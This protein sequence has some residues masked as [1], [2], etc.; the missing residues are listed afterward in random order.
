MKSYFYV[1]F[2]FFSFQAQAQNFYKVSGTA[3]DKNQKL[4]L[5]G[6]YVFINRSSDNKEWAVSTDAQGN[7]NFDGLASGQYT[8]K[9]TYIGFKAKQQALEISQKDIFLGEILLDEDPLLLKQ[10]DIIGKLPPAEQK[11]DTTQ[12]NAKAF[13][14]NPD[15]N[16]EDLLQ[17]MPGV[18]LQNGKIQAQ[19]E[20]VKQVLVD[21]K[22]FFG[23]DPNA[24]LKNLP[25]EIIDKIQ[26]FDQNSEQSQFTGFNDGNTT[27]TINIVTKPE[28][29][30]GQFGQFYAGYGYEDKYQGGGNLNVFDKNRRVSILGQSNNINQQNFSTEDLLGVAGSSGR[31]GG[32]RGGGDA[33]MGGGFGGGMG[34]GLLGGGVG[35]DVGDFLVGQQNGISTTHAFGLN[36]SDNW[37][38]KVELTASYFFNRSNNDARQL[39]NR[40]YFQDSDTT[41]QYAEN[42]LEG[43]EN[44]NHRFNLRLQYQIDTKNSIIIR[45]SAGIQQND[46][47][48]LNVGQNTWGE[49]TLNSTDNSFRSDLKGANFTNNLLFRHRFDKLGR[50]FSVNVGTGYNTNKGESFLL[51]ENRFL[52]ET[53]E[54]VD[55]LNQ[56][57][58]LDAQGWNVSSNLVYTE[59]L[60]KGLGNMLMF[61]YDIQYQLN[62]S[63]KETFNFSSDTESYDRLDSTLSNTFSSHYLTHA[64]GVGWMKR[65]NKL[66]TM[67]RLNLQWAELNSHPIIPASDDIQRNFYN[68]LPFFM[69][70]YDI[71]KEKNLRL[72][73]RTHTTAPSVSQLQNVINNSNPLQL[74]TGNPNLDQNYQHNLFL[75]YNATKADKSGVFFALLRLQYTDNHFANSTLIAQQDTV[76]N[77]QVMLQRG[78]Q[79][80]RPVNLDGYWSSRM[81]VSYGVPVSF[82]KSNFNVDF[83][84]D[85]ARSPGLINEKTNFAN[86]TT[87]GIGL[88][89]SSN[90]SEK[91]DFTVSTRSQYNWVDNSLR[92]DLNDQYVNQNTQLKLTWILWKGWV[93]R[94]N[95]NHQAYFGLSEGFDQNFWLWNLEIGKKLFK[96]ELGEIKIAV[97]DLLKQ[98]NSLQR[99]ISEVYLE[100]TETEVL[101]RYFMLSFTYRLKAFKEKKP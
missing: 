62:D 10:I 47:F 64:L 2:I 74:S 69:L 15:A 40:D 90:I 89:L 98:N 71:S 55:S 93:F 76:L 34:G 39:I 66:V 73:Y 41:Q 97:F 85:Y 9:I 72:F 80:T 45:T 28:M 87:L 82:L 61:N 18:N 46:G 5:V 53:E 81:F 50:T 6:A 19:G 7:F 95:L 37:G 23:N 24:A 65:K 38:K 21:G 86:T 91:I 16:A 36:Y 59:P 44:T 33:R 68:A 67:L 60:G 30:N 42:S 31:R 75:R 101:Q 49:L 29:R 52:G 100:D 54:F 84:A 96:N 92:Q 20:D 32:A 99:T 51:S 77:D 13:K 94:S 79:I 26:I 88:V 78:A 83:S 58:M 25:A 3:L 27:K 14:T 22:P 48:S 11:G 17:K 12:Y 57:S 8:L 35:S 4:P 43:S 1:F 56:F 70:R 63:Q